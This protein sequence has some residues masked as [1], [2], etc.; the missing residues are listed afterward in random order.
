LADIPIEMA[1]TQY[2]TTLGE[3]FASIGGEQIMIQSLR[4]A[5]RRAWLTLAFILPTVLVVGLTVR[6][7]LLHADSKSHK[8]KT[9]QPIRQS[10]QLWKKHAIHS[11]F[12]RDTSDPTTVQVV[13]E[14][15]DDFPAPDLLVYW[16]R[17]L[18]GSDQL[19]IEAVLLGAFEDG[20]P[21]QLQESNPRGFLILYSLAHQSIVDSASLESLL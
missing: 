1:S 2:G 16:S 10:D 9:W 15:L 12:L 21:L 17:D 20:K 11:V 6:R 14:P 3:E 7:P 8:S 4:S 5:H 19:P 13:L 18:S